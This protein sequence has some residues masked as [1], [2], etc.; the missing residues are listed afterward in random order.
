[1]GPSFS[2]G[3]SM[4][5]T[6]K[7]LIQ[8]SS[9]SLTLKKGRYSIMKEALLNIK[10]KWLL[11]TLLGGGI[12]GAGFGLLFATKAGKEIRNDI[13]ELAA[14]TR[15]KVGKTIDE[16]IHVYEKSKN[17]VTSAIDCGTAAFAEKGR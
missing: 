11:F 14:R 6:R 2:S 15:D 3:Q 7:Y 16:G 1:M 17:A 13:K 8:C 4:G 10:G 9:G 12:L 5:F